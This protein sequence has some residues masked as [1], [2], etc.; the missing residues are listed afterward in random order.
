MARKVSVN[1]NGRKEFSVLAYNFRV[2]GPTGILSV[3]SFVKEILKCPNLLF[4]GTAFPCE[5]ILPL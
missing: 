5:I 3:S 2:D 4:I 1:I